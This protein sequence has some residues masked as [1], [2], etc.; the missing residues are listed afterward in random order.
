MSGLIGDAATAAVLLRELPI[1]WDGRASILEMRNANYNWRQMEWW[2]FF[3]ELKARALLSK[4]FTIPGKRYNTVTFDLARSVN[5]DMKAK[6]T[7]SKDHLAILND[8]SAMEA[9]IHEYKEHGVILAF[10]DV[11]YDD[12]D[13]TFQN[14]HSDLKGGESK[15]EIARKQRTE[16]SRLRKTRADLREIVFLRIDASNL[17][18]LNIM[19]QGQNSNGRARPEKFVL[20]LKKIDLFEVNRINFESTL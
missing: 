19:K 13:R 15:Y 12:V 5:W 20:D 7:M 18:L 14:W 16:N 4:E 6:A 11:K 1:E 9:S 3:F 2:A 8:K 17:T 10:C